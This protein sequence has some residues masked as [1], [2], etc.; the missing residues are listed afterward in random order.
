MLAD[1]EFVWPDVGLNFITLG[2]NSAISSVFSTCFPLFSFILI[3]SSFA[4]TRIAHG[5]FDSNPWLKSITHRGIEKK[6]RVHET[7]YAVTSDQAPS[8]SVINADWLAGALLSL[9]PI[10]F[11]PPEDPANPATARSGL[12]NPPCCKDEMPSSKGP[13]ISCFSKPSVVRAFSG[14]HSGIRGCLS[15]SVSVCSLLFSR[16][17]GVSWL[18]LEAESG[19]E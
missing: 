19:W 8:S 10:F 4:V 7:R 9:A 2:E 6:G 5:H 12:G 13:F 14:R 17:R 16:G 11:P 18:R 1:R 15:C 3:S